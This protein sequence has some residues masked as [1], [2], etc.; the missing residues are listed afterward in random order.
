MPTRRTFV[1]LLSIGT[2]VGLLGGRRGSANPPTPPSVES[3]LKNDR[4][5]V[6]LPG[7]AGNRL[8]GREFVNADGTVFESKFGTLLQWQFQRNPQREEKKADDWAPPVQPLPPDL[9]AGTSPAAQDALVW[10][11]HATWLI[12]WGGRRI[13][14]DPVFFNVSLVKRR[15]AHKPRRRP[16]KHDGDNARN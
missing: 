16:S 4:L 15:H 5:P 7:W 13:L 11:G 1:R 9:Q 10:L 12:Q 14:T 8:V 6:V 3:L 2:I